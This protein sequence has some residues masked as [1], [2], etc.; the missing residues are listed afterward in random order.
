VIQIEKFAPGLAVDTG[1]FLD[2]HTSGKPRARGNRD[3]ATTTTTLATAIPERPAASRRALVGWVLFDWAGQPYYTLI[4]TFLFAPYFANV[5]VGDSARGQAIWG[6]A[7]AA[8]GILVAIGSPLLGAMADGRGRRK[9]WIALF[10]LVLVSSMA[11]LWFAK[12]G[13][14]GLALWGIVL[15]FVVATLAAEFATVF[16]NAIMPTLVPQSQI[17]R[18]SGIG[19]A[20]GYAGGLISLAVMAGLIVTNPGT[21]KTLLGLEPVLALDAGAREGDRL[22]GPF[23]AAWYLLF[24]IPFFLFVP[25]VGGNKIAREARPSPLAELLTTLRE[26]PQHRDMLWFLIARAIYVDGLSAIFTFGG[27]YGASVF[28]WQ[29]FELGLFGIILTLTGAI[30]AV[31]GGFLDDRWGSKR[32]ILGSLVILLAGAIGILSVSA[33]QV[34]FTVEVAPKDV[35]SKPFTSTGE[36]VYLAFAMLIGVVAAPVQAASRSLLAHLAPP[37]KMTQFFGLFAF[38]GK[39]TAFAAPFLIATVTAATGNQRAG[40]AVIAAFLITGMLLMLPVRER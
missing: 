3:L 1:E 35:G 14:S 15:A 34:L 13:T 4:L 9:P 6:Y 27:I 33:S 8:A 30:G 17:G 22:V 28:G 36:L 40:M 7:A 26:L 25:D 19:W 11:V 16:T 38:S 29:A 39:V 37:D 5:V 23:S 24:M 18:L 2:H 12:P 32:V 21:G 20:C 31:I 10:S